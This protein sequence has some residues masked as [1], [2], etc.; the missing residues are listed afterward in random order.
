MNSLK[1]HT[2]GI[3][4][5]I[6]A[7]L[8]LLVFHPLLGPG[9]VLF[10]TDDNLGDVSRNKS[11]LN[12]FAGRWYDTPLF[13]FGGGRNL[14]T[15][16]NFC[17]YIL[18][19]IAFKNWFQAVNLAGASLFLAMFLRERKLGLPAQ[20]L[21]ALTAFW[22]GSNFTLIYA[23]HILK[24]AT[25]F[26]AMVS[27]WSL[28]RAIQQRSFLWSFVTGGTIGFMMLEQQDVALFIGIFL[29]A[30]AL[31]EFYRF[32]KFNLPLFL[33]I[34]AP[35][36]LCALMIGGPNALS[37]YAANVGGAKK[38][39]AQTT[40]DERESPAQQ[41]EF[42]TQW[43]W[44]PEECVDFI[45]PGYTGWRSGEPEGPYWGR[46]GRSAGWERTGQGFMN[47]KLE[48]HYLGAIPVFLALFAIAAA[49]VRQQANAHSILNP[50]DGN[51]AE[52]IFWAGAAAVAL[53][54]SFG[55]YFPL[56]YL[57]YQLPLVNSIRNPNKFLHVFQIALGILAAYGLDIIIKRKIAA[58][59][60]NS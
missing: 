40:P 1:K 41:W 56:Y 19:A 37:V 57:F 51:R 5:L 49:L 45:A 9:N 33:R 18:P 52:I 54:L 44:P 6:I 48:N 8:V 60:V 13:G 31:Y 22:L 36:A 3:V 29:A 12:F 27:L 28:D 24:Y 34:F 35:M 46:M 4:I 23:G 25:M 43:S 53:L 58:I 38:S 16:T 39:E 7:F 20:I 32:E 21:A 59:N 26:L 11:L 55:K 50:S 42:A 2:I 14:F 47:F 10:S 15:W 17:F 30:F